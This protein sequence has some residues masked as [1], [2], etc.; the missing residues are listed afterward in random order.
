MTTMSVASIVKAALAC[1]TLVPTTLSPRGILIG[2][3]VQFDDTKEELKGPGDTGKIDGGGWMVGPY[4]G[5]LLAPNLMLDVRAAW[6]RSGND[7]VQDDGETGPTSASF[8]TT[9]WLATASLT[10]SHY[11]GPWRISPRLAVAFGREEFDTFTNSA[12]VIV[13]GDEVSIGRVTGT[14]EVGYRMITASGTRV[15]P[16]AS[17]SGLHNFKDEDILVDG[18]L[19]EESKSRAKVEAGILVSLPNGW[20]MRA[21]GHYD[22][23]GG[24]DFESYGGGLWVNIPLSRQP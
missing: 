19:V 6:G 5:V 18:V 20:G 17:I 3:L 12:G 1:S 22:G 13:N 11:Y 15:E 16:H 8:D 14:I 23:I 7:I 24:D 21:A 9:R 4:F 10:G 2:G